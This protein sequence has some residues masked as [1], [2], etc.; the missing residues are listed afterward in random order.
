MQVSGLWDY[1]LHDGKAL[2]DLLSLK[3]FWDLLIKSSKSF[4]TLKYDMLKWKGKWAWSKN[5]TVSILVLLHN[6]QCWVNHLTYLS[7]SILICKMKKLLI[8]SQGSG[9]E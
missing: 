6:K 4:L 7:L 3:D 1:V 2:Y 5:V 9:Q 8:I